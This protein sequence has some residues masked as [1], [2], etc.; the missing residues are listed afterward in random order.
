MIFV[1]LFSLL[2]LRGMTRAARTSPPP[3]EAALGPRLVLP[4]EVE[5]EQE[6][7]MSEAPALKRRARS[8]GP[9]LREELTEMVK[10]DPDAAANILRNWIGD[11]A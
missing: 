2:M 5:T 4:G 8:T 6:A 1:G 10:E 3:E 7:Q 9:G 11:A